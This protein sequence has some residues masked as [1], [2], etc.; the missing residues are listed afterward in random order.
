MAELLDPRDCPYVGLDPFVPAYERFFF[1]REQDSR[2]IADHVASRPITVLYGASGVGKSSVLNVGLPAALRRRAPWM[3]VTLRDWQDPDAIEQRAI[4]A[5]EEAIPA[6][7]VRRSI[8]GRFPRR[9]VGALRASGLPLLLIFD[10]FE[11]YFL[12]RGGTLLTSVEKAMGVL[13]ARRDLDVRVL[14][15]LR[16]DSLHLLDKLRAIVPGI[17]ETTIRLGHLNDVAAEQAIRGPIRQYNED[18]RKDVEPVKIDDALVRTLIGDLRH[19]AGRSIGEAVGSGP[20]EPIELPYLQLTMTKLWFAEGGIGA[21]ALRL[22]ALMKKLGGVQ[23]IAREHVDRILSGLTPKE[24]ALCADLFRNLVTSGGGKIAYPTNDLAKQISEDRKQASGGRDLD[25]VSTEEVAAVLH[26]LT[27]TPTRLLKPVRA[28][29]VDAYELFHDVLGQP[30]LRWRRDFNA[31]ARL[32]AEQKRKRR[33]QWLAGV[34]AFVMI[35]AFAFAVDA[36]L[37]TVGVSETLG[38]SVWSAL[39]FERPSL[40]SSDVDGLWRITE[41]ND[42]QRDGFLSPLTGRYFHRTP[43]ARIAAWAGASMRPMGFQLL[44]E[45]RPDPNLVERFAR[46]P[47]NVLRALGL[48]PLA[49]AQSQAAIE[50]ILAAIYRPTTDDNTLLSLAKTFQ[51]LPV[52][53]NAAQTQTAVDAILARMER[54]P[55]SSEL[56]ALALALGAL[57]AKLTDAQAKTAID[58]MLAAMKQA[59]PWPGLVYYSRLE[60]LAQGL[61]ALPA[62]L[63]AAQA[64]EALDP[65]LMAVER[66]AATDRFGFGTLAGALAALAPKLGAQEA[67]AAIDRILAGIIERRVDVGLLTTDSLWQA[68]RALSARLAFTETRVAIDPILAALELRTDPEALRSLAAVLPAVAA[69]V[70]DTKTKAAFELI[71][72][73]VDGATDHDSWSLA[74]ALPAFAARLTA[75][76]AEAAV[77]PILAAIKRTTDADPLYFLSRALRALP[78]KLTDPQAQRALDPILAAME[79]ATDP[80]ALRSLAQALWTLQIPLTDAQAQSA[81]DPILAAIKQTTVPSSLA[82]LADSLQTLSVKLTTAQAKEVVDPILAAIQRSDVPNSVQQLA[83]A[84]RSLSTTL[85]DAQAQATIDPIASAV[86]RTSDPDT[87]RSLAQALQSLAPKVTDARARQLELFALDHFGQA[88]ND[89]VVEAWAGAFAAFA[90]RDRDDMAFLG[91]IVEA[92]KYPT[93]AGKPTETLMAALRQR[94]A[95]IPE[96]KGGLDAAVPW[97]EKK[98]GADVVSRPPNQPI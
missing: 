91:A 46:R 52:R 49:E 74:Q 54:A 14:I 11:E 33:A 80:Y 84:L 90:A 62:N 24:Q 21:K 34:F 12:Y 96:L 13:L 86:E 31:N 32:R 68:L 71:L 36:Y 66:S 93:A 72:R 55:N 35:L 19:G 95:D 16:D 65:I 42:D 48:R 51:A 69:A 25:S 73:A 39:E 40:S 61:Q 2:V 23:Q 79:R 77:E 75:A 28:N 5:L 97:F 30:I 85:P 87:R 8:H 64:Q 45:A 60:S 15:A 43:L 78:A 1:G 88:D 20:S 3:I 67:K 18:Y 83:Q 44:D 98:L 89:N 53:L 27:P 10:Q 50:Q 76:D 81:I 29:G 56:E 6:S 82:S 58:P 38:R 57:P 37:Q 22:E 92:L 7:V 47:A 17:L 94:F 59:E 4:E 41:L 26:K 70:P 9:V 63:T